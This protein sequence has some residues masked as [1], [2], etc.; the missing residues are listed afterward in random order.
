MTHTTRPSSKGSR[1]LG[2]L[3]FASALPCRRW[4]RLRAEGTAGRLRAQKLTGG[5]STPSNSLW[6]TRTAYTPV[7]KKETKPR[8]VS[9]G[10]A[11]HRLGPPGLAG[12]RSTPLP[13]SNGLHAFCEGGNQASPRLAPQSHAQPGLNPPC[14][15]TPHHDLAFAGTP[16]PDS[17]GLHAY[18]E[19]GNQ[20]MPCPALPCQ[21][22]HCPA[23]HC[24]G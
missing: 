21:A 10:L 9:P 16:L 1:S 15:G 7:V 17:N 8:Q 23:W 18:R 22:K 14:H 12:P 4:R 5:L 3:L 13:D 24:P 6:P 2:P 20:A 19:G 11:M